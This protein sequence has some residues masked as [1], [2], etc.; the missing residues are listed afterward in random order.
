MFDK[1]D[2]PNEFVPSACDRRRGSSVTSIVEAYT[3]R[4]E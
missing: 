3:R 4:H 2:D 1:C